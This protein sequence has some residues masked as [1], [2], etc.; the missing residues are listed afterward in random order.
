MSD[1]YF[2]GDPAE[3]SAR[4]HMERVLKGE[5]P[6]RWPLVAALLAGGKAFTLWRLRQSRQAKGADAQPV[7][8]PTAVPGRTTPQGNEGS[9][10]RT[11]LTRRR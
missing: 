10:S 2:S 6:R 9:V 1:I 3:D 11:P 5:Q 7:T 8:R 4:R